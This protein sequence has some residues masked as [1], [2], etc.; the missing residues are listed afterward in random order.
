[1]KTQKIHDNA[2]RALKQAIKEVVNNHKKAH[3]PLAIWQNGKVV[4]ILPKKK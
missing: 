4:S 3:R 2:Q 1:M